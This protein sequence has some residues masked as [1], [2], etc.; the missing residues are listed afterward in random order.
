MDFKQL[1]SELMGIANQPQ[2][3]AS[4]Y[5]DVRRDSEHSRQA[6]RI[7]VRDEIRRALKALPDEDAKE[8]LRKTLHPIEE[9][10]EGL[11]RQRHEEPEAGLAIFASAPLGLFRVVGTSLPF[12]P[13]EF[14]LAPRPRL[15]SLMRQ[16]SAPP[17]IVEA[18]D[19]EGARLYE[20]GTGTVDLE[21]R[22]DRPFPGMHHQGGWSQRNFQQ[23]LGQLR[24][25]NLQ[26]G[27]EPLIRLSDALPEAAVVLAGQSFILARF[28][29]ELPQRT[30]E[31]VIGRL[32]LPSG[33]RNGELRDL[34]VREARGQLMEHLANRR[35]GMRQAVMYDISRNGGQAAMGI[36][37][38]TQVVLEG[39]A[40]R[41]LL[42]SDLAR[43]GWRCTRC[44][45]IGSEENASSTPCPSC[46]GP[47]EAVNLP[48][49]L[50]RRVARDG[51]EVV[52]LRGE[53]RMPP[54]TGMAVWL[55]RPRP[56]ARVELGAPLSPAPA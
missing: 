39:R 41:L 15:I 22:F 32:S 46:A 42:D 25:R 2:P 17:L 23:H 56:E 31:R 48:E 45:A 38:T 47:R 50:A 9:Y 3:I 52:F 44:Q 27:A 21:A 16:L 18:V 40:H 34:L 51:G 20:L 24:Q 33:L 7:F 1:L 49:E 5:L 8:A 53:E 28:E 11:L 10:V 6:L 12:A 29:E 43:A 4:V 13:Q 19:S 37:A 55:R 14:H 26:A 35:A 36:D 54:G 30:R